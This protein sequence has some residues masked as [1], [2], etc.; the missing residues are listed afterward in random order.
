[1]TM[2]LLIGTVLSTFEVEHNLEILGF[3]W[4]CCHFKSVN[5]IDYVVL[6]ELDRER[7]M[8][9]RYGI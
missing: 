7:C 3:F 4:R 9:K 8:V 1:M 2:K 5:I 6:V